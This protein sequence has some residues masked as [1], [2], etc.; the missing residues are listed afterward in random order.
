MALF[1][2]AETFRG[3]TQIVTEELEGMW[4][5]RG[6]EDR[7]WILAPTVDRLTTKGISHRLFEQELLFEFELRAR[8]YLRRRPADTWELLALAQHHGLPTRLLDWTSNPLVA[9]Y[10][11]VENPACATDS[12]VWCLSRNEE[13]TSSRRKQPFDIDS[14]SFYDPPHVSP[15]ITPQSGLFTVHPPAL[16][17]W[18]NRPWPGERAMIEIPRHG[19]Q[20][21]RDSLARCGIHSASLFPDLDGLSRFLARQWLP[22]VHMMRDTYDSSASLAWVKSVKSGWV[23]VIRK[24]LLNHS[25]GKF[26]RAHVDWHEDE[27]RSKPAITSSI[28]RLEDLTQL[29]FHDPFPDL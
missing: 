19:R 22:P 25:N 12:A 24:T 10:F 26:D 13:V 27:R 6:H 18:H 17:G 9:L 21:I 28:E 16:E 20:N 29:D 4:V 7:D 5:F 1:F 15:R 8:P 2:V 3:F 14:I 23:G 11:A